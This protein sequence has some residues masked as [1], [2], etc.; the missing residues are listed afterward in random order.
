MSNLHT[1]TNDL[2]KFSGDRPPPETPV[3]HSRKV[4]V[5]KPPY[6]GLSFQGL[7][8]TSV[9]EVA[10]TLGDAGVTALACL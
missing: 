5:L 3:P 6:R 1:C 4:E 2:Q 8:S 7:S 9:R 10:P